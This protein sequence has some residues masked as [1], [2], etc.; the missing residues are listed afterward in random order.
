[1][2]ILTQRSPVPTI[3]RRFDWRAIVE[4][5]DSPDD[6]IGLG[7]TEME[8]VQDLMTELESA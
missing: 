4:G 5:K 7:A 2:N 3:D 8:A 6:P 1:V